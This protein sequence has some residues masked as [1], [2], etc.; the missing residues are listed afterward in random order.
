MKRTARI[1][2]VSLLALTHR[3]NAAA[4]PPAAQTE[5]FEQRIRPLLASE[6]Y[7]CHGAKKQKGGLR[8]DFRDGLIKGGDSGPAIISG[9]AKKSLL[10]QAIRHEDPDSAMPK[11]R[12]KLSD[13]VIADF[14]A[15]VDQG[16]AD[17]RDTPPREAAVSDKAWAATFAARKDWWSFKPIQKP[18]VPGV[19]NAGWSSHPVD[20]FLLEG[21]EARGLEPASAADRRTLIRRLSFTLTGLPPTAEEVHAFVNNP[22]P[23]AYEQLVA[24]LLESPRFGEHWAR[25]WMDLMRF[26]ETHGSEGDPDI[27][28]AWRYRDYL[29][30][31]FNADIPS[32]Q[33][34]REHLAGDLLAQPRWNPSEGINESLLGI[35]H[36]RLVEHG[37]NPVDTLDEQIKT[38]D[39]QIDV[40]SKAFQGLT[41]S[42]ARCHDHKFD[43]I[44]VRDYYALHGIF[45]S[46]RPTQITIDAPE[47]LR[48]HR[49]E[50]EDLKRTIKSR[51]ADAWEIAAAEISQ[52][53]LSQSRG[54]NRLT[55][56]GDELHTD[57]AEME[58]RIAAIDRVGRA[59]ALQTAVRQRAP[60]IRPGSSGNSSNQSSSG[61]QSRQD[62][63]DTPSGSASEP[64]AM[65]MAAWTFDGDARDVVGG[66]HG[67]LHGGAVIRNGRLILDGK[68][69]FLRTAP[70]ERPLREKTLE[71][72]VT[73]SSLDQA[74]GGVITVESQDGGIFDS[75]VFA[76]K[77][78]RQWTVGS[79]FYR[80]SQN[81]DGPKESAKPGEL[82]HLVIVYRTNHSIAL[83]RNGAAY[84]G[85][86][87]PS[88]E[89]ATLRTF[90]EKSA[91]VVLGMRHTGGGNAFL[92][93]EIEEARI[94]ERA[95]SAREIKAWFDA[96]PGLVAAAEIARALTPEQR[97]E[98]QQLVANIASRRAALEK[99][100]PD[101]EKR[102]AARTR[103][104]L[105]IE[106]A[107]KD[108]NQPLHPWAI[109]RNKSGREFTNAWQAFASRHREELAAR[110]RF[111]NENFKPAWDFR[112]DDVELWFRHGANPPE[113]ITRPGEFS[114]EPDGDRVLVGLLPAGVITHRLSQKHHGIFA[115]PRFRITNDNI[116]VRVVGGKGAGVR[117]VLDNYPL[118]QGSIYP[119]TDLNSDAPT[120]VRLDVAYRKGSM[121]YLEFAT[122]EE[123]TSR[124]RAPSGPGGR[125][126]FGI[127]RVVFHDNKATP[128]EETTPHALVLKSAAPG[129]TTDLAKQLSARL[130]ECIIAWRK[131]SLSEEQ[132]V[133]LDAFVRAGLLPV[134]LKDLPEASSLV[135]E[136][137][138][139]ESNI[140]EAR[141]APG[142]LETVGHDAPLLSRGDHLKPLSPVPRGYLEL[143]SS[144]PYAT[145]QSGRLELAHDIAS[146]ENPLT[147]RVLVNRIWHHLFGRGLVATVD[148][149]GRLGEK[150]S[151]PELLDFLATRFIEQGWSSKELIRYLVTTRAY[152]MSSDASARAREMDP[153][154]QLLSHARL[155]RL[156]AES[157]RDSLLALSGRLDSSMFGPGANAL[158]PANG[159]RRRSV[160]LTVRR[161]FL[162]PFLETFDAPRPFS[163]LGRRETTNVPAQSLALLNDPFVL[164][165]AAQWAVITMREA[166]PNLRVRRMFEAALA[167]PPSD[168]ELAAS[169]G[170]LADL[171]REHGAENDRLIWSDFAQSLFNLKEFI[172]IR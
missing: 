111:N 166:D 83:F 128:K 75:I 98:R 29:I 64:V 39:S 43:P 114:I 54:T 55:I 71:A 68:G 1:V 20:R 35:A 169:R 10:I 5:F 41:I 63:G 172:Y 61:L 90:T 163:T 65:P 72:W 44:G 36:L 88:G 100:F 120:W 155:R 135:T 109:V 148:N 168:A 96:G 139:L 11:D 3:V 60:G 86:Y 8:V 14:V 110:R 45:A 132:R 32:D 154:N 134:T 66:L 81:L 119:G 53:L 144:R 143:L 52:H 78:P 106:S 49:D 167:R 38:I 73:L 137:R 91:R 115:S 127:E 6:C 57:I 15:W 107:E 42:C 26:A 95:L 59:T 121:A 23:E 28:N 160:Y 62:V 24:R 101:H 82:V 19:K 13:A 146:A 104:L 25:H 102:D 56:P 145:Q 118:G 33:L 37:F 16:A 140:P 131:N 76:E 46:V 149:L 51:V 170:Y 130:N 12:P 141:H 84:G 151:H 116:S 108:S 17:P 4:Q 125:S 67:E 85:A 162:S 93:G 9:N 30:R 18:P 112:G 126:F 122:R 7:E 103:V 133:F 150:P 153:D 129:S 99:E 117:L 94:Y 40:V 165:Q 156:E 105:A 157:I 69:A 123:V 70:L 27:P 79:D 161:N 152:Q 159:Q 21:M 147:A 171:A 2:L 89:N 142:V 124:N 158:A 77:E 47:R 164:E 50:L 92:A 87:T 97:T 22:A 136:F 58:E 31:A 113:G 34:I 48:V 80:R 138:R 74:G